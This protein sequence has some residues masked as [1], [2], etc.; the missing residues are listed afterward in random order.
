MQYDFVG[1]G[2]CSN[3]HLCLLPS[4]PIDSKVRMQEHQIQGGGPAGTATVAAARLGW[5]AAFCSVVGDDPDGRQILADFVRENV[6]T[7]GVRVRPGASS[8]IAYCWIDA[9]TGHRSVAWTAEGLD[10][11]RPDEVDMDLVRNAR[12]LHLDGHDP[13]AAIAAAKAAREAGTVVNFDC[14]TFRD[15]TEELMRLADIL[16]T[17]EEFARKYTGEDDLERAVRKLGEIGARVTGLTMGSR[18]S[19]ALAPDGSI[20]RCPTFNEVKVVDT[21]GAGDVFH[22]GFAIRYVETGDLLESMRFA[23]AVSS[24]KCTKLGGRDG[25]PTR[26]EV[27]AFLAER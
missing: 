13:V 18:G 14:G 24:L 7:A 16:I 20:L 8:A 4:I 21:T 10:E 12:I 27:E 1:L 26:A 3:D 19:M 2:Y 6:A 9:P 17:S 23:S 25:I 22:T 15:G 5:S 11:L